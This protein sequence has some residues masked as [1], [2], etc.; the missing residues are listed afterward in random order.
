MAEIGRP[1]FLDVGVDFGVGVGVGVGVGAEAMLPHDLDPALLRIGDW[2][3]DN[4]CLYSTTSDP[5]SL[6]IIAVSFPDGE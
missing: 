1:G 3:L 2:G 4:N 5:G 6:I